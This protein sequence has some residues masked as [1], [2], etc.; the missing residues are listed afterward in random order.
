[1]SKTAKQEGAEE[2]KAEK[3]E[4]VAVSKKPFFFP[5]REVAILAET[6]EEATAIYN[7]RY[8]SNA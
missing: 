2:V 4:P 7:S 8:N 3:A 6:L 1:M 5:E